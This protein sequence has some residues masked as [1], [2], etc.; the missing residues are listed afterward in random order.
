MCFEL[1]TIQIF[2]R[3]QDLLARFPHIP[4]QRQQWDIASFFAVSSA[5]TL[6]TYKTVQISKLESAI[7]VRFRKLIFSQTSFASTI[8]TFTSWMT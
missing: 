5:L 4:G 7:E 1:Y 8:S 3:F 2:K 6:A